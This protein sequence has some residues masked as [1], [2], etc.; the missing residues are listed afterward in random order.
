MSF[1][2]RPNAPDDKAVKIIITVFTLLF[3]IIFMHVTNFSVQNRYGD[4]QSL[5]NVI[6]HGDLVSRDAVPDDTLLPYIPRMTRE[7]CC[8]VTYYDGFPPLVNWSGGL[9]SGG[10]GDLAKYRIVTA[11]WAYAATLLFFFSLRKIANIYVATLALFLIVLQEQ[12]WATFVTQIYNLADVFVWLTVFWLAKRRMEDKPVDY[13]SVVVLFFLASM[14]S[15]EYVLFSLVLGAW[16]FWGRGRRYWLMRMAVAFGGATLGVVFKTMLALPARGGVGAA[17]NEQISR[18]MVRVMDKGA[19][20]SVIDRF[21]GGMNNYPA[22]LAERFSYHYA[23]F[24]LFL[25]TLVLLMLARWRFKIPGVSVSFLG[26]LIL[27]TF[28]WL[29]VFPQHTVVHVNLIIVRHWIYLVAFVMAGGFYVGARLLFESGYLKKGFGVACF[30]FA[31][32]FTWMNLANFGDFYERG[33]RITWAN[34]LNYLTATCG[35]LANGDICYVDDALH[36]R[37]AFLHQ[38]LPNYGLPDVTVKLKSE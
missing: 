31:A 10:G 20:V 36:L 9:I 37:A 5:A 28:A 1:Q 13:Y 12:Y 21:A 22:F 19:E 11:F 25:G 15:Y 14:T 24:W 18:I 17:I 2:A 6:V 8:H 35:G 7:Q 27:A 16:L 26:F 32:T 3:F 23:P 38:P 33:Y 29:I 4:A 34:E 30:A